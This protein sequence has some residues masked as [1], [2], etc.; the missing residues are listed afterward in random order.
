MAT[1]ETRPSTVTVNKMGRQQQQLPIPQIHLKFAESSS[2]GSRWSFL[3]FL[4]LAPTEK[5]LVHVIEMLG[6][7]EKIERNSVFALLLPF[8]IATH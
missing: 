5:T 4:A 8:K 7:I 6:S 2:V 3:P 1:A